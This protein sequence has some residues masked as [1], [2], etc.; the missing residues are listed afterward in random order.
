MNN[1]IYL[2]P[3]LANHRRGRLLSRLLNTTAVDDNLPDS[4]LMLSIGQDFQTLDAQ[5]Q[6][7]LKA[8][9]QLPGRTLL[10]LPPFKEGIVSPPLDWSMAYRESPEAKEADVSTPETLAGILSEEVTLSLFGHD[11]SFDQTSEY[12]WR[13]GSPNCR[14]NKKHSGSGVFAATTLPLWSISV[15]EKKQE[16]QSWLAALHSHAGDASTLNQH[17]ENIITLEPVDYTTM[18]C[19]YGW[20][21]ADRKEL[22]RKVSG[23]SGVA[24]FSIEP[25]ALEESLDRLNKLGCLQTARKATLTLSLHGTEALAASPYWGYAEH[26]LLESSRAQIKENRGEND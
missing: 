17:P 7:R 6:A 10:L 1:E 12:Q 3:A 23:K 5:E 14:Y 9:C 26:L 19:I 16:L 11:G 15:M 13:D 8:W 20:Q 18:V 4:G 22:F 2:Q 21:C 24:L 25:D